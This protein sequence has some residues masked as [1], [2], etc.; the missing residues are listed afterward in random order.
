MYCLKVFL[1]AEK[2]LFP[3]F[4]KFPYLCHLVGW[5][6]PGLSGCAWQRAS[7]PSGQLR[8]GGSGFPAAG[9]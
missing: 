8:P 7:R 4:L 1:Q 6:S 3:V 9:L 5:S 2:I